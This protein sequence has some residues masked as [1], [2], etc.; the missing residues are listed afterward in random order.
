RPSSA[1]LR[2]A[3]STRL[4]AAIRHATTQLSREPAS[5]HVLIV[6]TDGV[7]SDEGYDG[8]YAHA[9]VAKAIEEG[10]R[11]RIATVI[12]VV[13]SDEDTAARFGRALTVVVGNEDT[14]TADLLGRFLVRGGEVE[15]KDGPVTDAVRKGAICY[16]DEVVEMRRE[17]LAA[18]HPLADHRRRVHLD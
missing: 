18:M 17:S 13:G 11:A 3:H 12:L 7:P 9:D 5:R 2:P 1:R 4:G 14:T 8:I 10:E 6:L 15:W 16:L